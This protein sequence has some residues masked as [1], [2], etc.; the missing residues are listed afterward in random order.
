MNLPAVDYRVT[1]TRAPVVVDDGLVLATVQ[2]R[3]HRDA[4]DLLCLM[5]A[6]H[7]APIRL[8]R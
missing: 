6:P 4:R 2:F 8:I 7:P 1:L 3:A 5:P